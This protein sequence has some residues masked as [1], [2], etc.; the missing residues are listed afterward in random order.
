[1]RLRYTDRAIEDLDIAFDWYEKQKRG[2]GFEFVACIEKSIKNIIRF[3]D[4]YKITH[5]NFHRCV[6]QRFPFSIF[7]SIENKVIVIHA[8]FDNRQDT[9]KIP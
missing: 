8:I 3:H 5:S 1:M 4:S 9:I 7:Y 2:L 6:I